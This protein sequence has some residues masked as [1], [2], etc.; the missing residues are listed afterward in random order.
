[1]IIQM[2]K[3]TSIRVVD[4]NKSRPQEYYGMYGYMIYKDQPVILRWSQP[5]NEDSL[6]F[7]LTKILEEDDARNK[8]EIN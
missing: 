8:A 2:E 4:R 6:L 3:Q 5:E 1:M 7:Q